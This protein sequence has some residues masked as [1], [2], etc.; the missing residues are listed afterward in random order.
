MESLE[1][2]SIRLAP[3]GSPAGVPDASET[4]FD[5]I[6][7]ST[8][9]GVRKEGGLEI[10]KELGKEIEVRR[11][12]DDGHP[13]WIIKFCAHLNFNVKNYYILR[14]RKMRPR[15]RK[16]T[17]KPKGEHPAHDQDHTPTPG[18]QEE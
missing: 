12:K 11:G 10:W 4:C 2:R 15:A 9:R 17:Q 14:T 5:S 16:E 1:R 6:R 18:G 7:F 3:C 8:C 13:I